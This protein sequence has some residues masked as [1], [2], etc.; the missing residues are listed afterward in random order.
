MACAFGVCVSDY[1]LFI[2]SVFS[3]RIYSGSNKHELV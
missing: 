1:A 3:L 2:P